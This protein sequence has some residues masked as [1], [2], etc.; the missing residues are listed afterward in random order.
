MKVCLITYDAPHRKTSDVFFKLQNQQKFSLSFLMVP[1]KSRPERDVLLPHRPRQFE[2]PKTRA[3]AESYD[4]PFHDYERRYDV[5]EESDY[6]IVCG[7]NILEPVFAN[8]GKILNCHSGLI[9][10]VR[11]LDSFKW[12]I[13]DGRPIGNT[14]HIIDEFA[15]AGH[16]LHQVKTP[17]FADDSI[18]EFAARH[19]SFEM[20][21]LS[22]FDKFLNGGVTFDLETGE[23]RMRMPKEIEQS[24]LHSFGDYKK[25]Y[26]GR[27]S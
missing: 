2:G 23:P 26:A 10:L 1:F 19:Y 20:W 4:L 6:L 15:D 18:E 24:M 5:L 17:I 21:I 13:L 12:A 3:L 8:S 11:G 7:A 9:P 14:L 22:N 27:N 16:V 25:K